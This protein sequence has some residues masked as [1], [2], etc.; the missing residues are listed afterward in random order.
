MVSK[1]FAPMQQRALITGAGSGIGKATAIAFANAGIHVV[2]I[3]RSEAKLQAVAQEAKSLG[4]EVKT[5]PFDLAAVDQVRAKVEAIDQEGPIDILVNNAGIGY[6]AELISTPLADWQC[7]LNLNLTSVFQCVQGI[8]PGMRTRQQGT[9][10]NVVSIAGRQTFAGW[11]AYCAS[12]FGLMGLSKTLAA[13][14]RTHG[15][16]VVAVCPGA[17][18][19]PLWDT[20]TVQVDF[21]RSAMLLPETVA[22]SILHTVLLPDQAVVEELVLMPKGGAL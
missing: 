5:Y 22:Q 7:I 12:K 20:E 11:G 8:L 4:V 17:V 2:L 14:E 15:I 18:N 10:V 6:T 1:D 19:T 9:I 13:E 16:R 3:G 21:D